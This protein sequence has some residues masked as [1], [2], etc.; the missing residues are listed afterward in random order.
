MVKMV[1]KRASVIQ[2]PLCVRL[3]YIQKGDSE[4]GLGNPQ[5]VVKAGGV[6]SRNLCFKN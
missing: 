5:P 3:F 6:V 4:V 1:L 2:F